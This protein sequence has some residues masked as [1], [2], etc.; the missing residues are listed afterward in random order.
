[1]GCPVCKKRMH[2]AETA[3]NATASEVVV[4]I[5]AVS[6]L[7]REGGHP[8]ACEYCLEKHV[9]V[10]A[11]Y[12]VEYAE[13]KAERTAERLLCYA[14]L[15]CAAEHA[16]ALGRTDFADKLARAA[17]ASSASGDFTAVLDLFYDLAGGRG[18]AGVSRLSA[19]G[20]LAHAE[21]DARRA[22][23]PYFAEKIR[24]LRREFAVADLEQVK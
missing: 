1:M 11:V 10:A 22:G 9:A 12:A 8:L 7:A 5:P 18:G 13:N 24:L 20:A 4:Q 19:I 2:E 17:D 15:A 23:R 6:V 16:R 21:E 3:A 14:H